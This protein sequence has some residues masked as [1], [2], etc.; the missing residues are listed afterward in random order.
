MTDSSTGPSTLDAA[1]SYAAR[2]WHVFP[3]HTPT[4]T[5]CSCRRDCDRIGKHPR[6]KNGLLDATTDPAT[7]RRWWKM[8]P[9]ANIAIRTG[10]VSG[11]AVLDQD[12]LKGGADGRSALERSYGPLPETVQG[13][14]GNGLHEFF[15][16]PGTPVKNGV[17]TLGAGLNIRGD[18]GY[19]VAPPSLHTSGKHY[20]WELSHLPDETP[21]APMPD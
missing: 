6:T 4:P 18:G 8:W 12:N 11:L 1:L 13:L 5:G 9:A 20:A 19:V 15:L 10:A 21:L 17:E 16:H 3:C 7:I 14:T 2:G